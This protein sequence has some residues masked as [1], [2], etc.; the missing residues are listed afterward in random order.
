M[1]AEFSIEAMAKRVEDRYAHALE[2]LA[3]L[4]AVL[5]AIVVSPPELGK[6]SVATVEPKEDV[7]QVKPKVKIPVNE[8]N[9][10]GAKTNSIRK[11]TSP[12]TGVSSPKLETPKPAPSKV[13]PK[14]R[15]PEP[16]PV[17]PKKSR[18]WMLGGRERAFLLSAS[19]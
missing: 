6:K 19:V 8:K 16:N 12:K 4:E 13:T 11:K 7:P 15:I 1:R 3:E 2:M 14:K 5:E 10:S 18:R 9:P 17:P